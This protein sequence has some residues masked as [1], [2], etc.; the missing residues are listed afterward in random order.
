MKTRTNRSGERPQLGQSMVEVALALPIFLILI[1]GVIEVSNLLNTKNRIATAARASTRFAAGGGQNPQIVAVISVTDTLDLS[2]DVWDIWIIKG[3]FN[4]QT[5]QFTDWSADASLTNGDGNPNT[6]SYG[7]G[8]TEIYSEVLAF[9]GDD[10]DSDPPTID[11]S[12]Q[13]FACVTKR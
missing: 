1:A 12:R 5:G 3:T 7:L 9:I 11:L 10:C 2:E 4:E 6:P 8:Q 13:T